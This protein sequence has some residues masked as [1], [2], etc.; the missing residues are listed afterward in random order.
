[1]AGLDYNI[2]LSVFFPFYIAIS[3]PS[4]IIMKKVR[5][6]VWLSSIVVVWSVIMVCS[7]LVHDFAGLLVVRSFLGIAEGGLYPG[8]VYYIT[9]WYPRHE[10]GFR[11]ALFFAMA[12]AAGAFGGLFARGISEMSGVA[13]KDGW[14]WIFIIEGLMTFCVGCTSYFAI[15]DYPAKY[16]SE[17]L[18]L[19]VLHELTILQCQVSF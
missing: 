4:N 12:T 5:P 17:F 8:V 3:V 7:G 10:C 1:M 16:T 9:M 2:A 19:V 11:M 13:G 14:A 18:Y 6:N 15:C